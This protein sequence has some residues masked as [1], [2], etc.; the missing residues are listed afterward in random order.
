[1]FWGYCRCESLISQNLAQAT[2]QISSILWEPGKQ[3]GILRHP[4]GHFIITMSTGEV[5][6]GPREPSSY[7]KVPSQDQTHLLTPQ[8]PLLCIVVR[9]YFR[10]GICIN[11]STQWSDSNVVEFP[12]NN[13]RF[14]GMLANFI[15]IFVR[16]HNVSLCI[17]KTY[18]LGIPNV[19]CHKLM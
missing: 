15:V 8:S 5:C 1:M 10:V 17:C 11:D 2:F 16:C 19:L 4:T 7:D 9:N 6:K 13:Y 14:V 18:G 12:H 3:A